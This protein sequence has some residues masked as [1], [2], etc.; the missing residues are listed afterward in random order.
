MAFEDE[1]DTGSLLLETGD[2]EHGSA[3]RSNAGSLLPG[4]WNHVILRMDRVARRARFVINGSDQ[5]HGSNEL[6]REF[7]SLAPLT[8]GMM[9]NGSYR[10]KGLL[11]E[12][13]IVALAD[14][15]SN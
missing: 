3:C 10:L 7:R 12:L 4:R 6:H 14:D 11:D 8:I 15:S 2:G 13:R 5:T 1:N 9:E